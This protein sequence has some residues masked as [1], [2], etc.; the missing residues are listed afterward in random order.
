MV[1]LVVAVLRASAASQ[2]Q[3][4]SL[5]IPGAEDESSLLDGIPRLDDDAPDGSGG[6][7]PGDG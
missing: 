5:L 6:Q 7:L 3:D 1:A 4:P 2:A